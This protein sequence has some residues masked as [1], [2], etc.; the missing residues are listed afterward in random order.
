MTTLAQ[1]RQVDEWIGATPDSVPPPR[2]RRR[3]TIIKYKYDYSRPAIDRLMDH[4]EFDTNGGCWLWSGPAGTGGRYELRAKFVVEIGTPDDLAYRVAYR[5]LVGPI[6]PG[7]S[8]CH[9]C[10]QPLCINPAH[11]FLGTQAD[12]V[13]DMWRKGRGDRSGLR[14]HLPG[15]AHPQAVLREADIVAIRRD[16]RS[17][18]DVARDYGVSKTSISY[19]RLRKTWRHVP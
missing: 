19:I 4:V 3:R 16:A 14:N 17:H 10:D 15:S 1:A 8:L 13:A 6:P 18:R 7:L 12:N 9:R 5:L 2:V 11:L